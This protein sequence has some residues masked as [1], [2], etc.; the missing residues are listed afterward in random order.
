MTDRTYAYQANDTAGAARVR[1]FMPCVASP[2][3]VSLWSPIAV[4]TTTK[5]HKHGRS[6]RPEVSHL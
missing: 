2:V 3:A 1:S 6:R 4:G 5:D